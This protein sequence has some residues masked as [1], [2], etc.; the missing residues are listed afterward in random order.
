MFLR[1]TWGKS[2]QNLIDQMVIRFMKKPGA[3]TFAMKIALASSSQMSN[4]TKMY[5]IDTNQQ[6][7][8]SQSSPRWTIHSPHR[9][10]S[11]KLI[12]HTSQ[13]HLKIQTKA[14]SHSEDRSSTWSF[15]TQKQRIRTPTAMIMIPA[16]RLSLPFVIR[17]Y[18]A[19]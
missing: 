7:L 14:L 16:N 3:S 18:P 15:P 8:E 10:N 1:I 19:S 6:S 4:P 5:I 17:S 12:N 2:L 11:K 9:T 13:T